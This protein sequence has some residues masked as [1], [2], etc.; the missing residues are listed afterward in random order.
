MIAQAKI[1]LIQEMVGDL[2]KE[3]IIWLSGYLSGLAG[4][5]TKLIPGETSLSNGSSAP[6][7]QKITIAYGTET[8]NA[9]KLASNLAAKAKKKG[10]QP[11]LVS[12]EQYK[13]TDLPKEEWFFTIISTQGE[14]E[15]P[16]GAKK[17]Y[18]FVHQ[19][20]VTLSKLNFGVLA[21]GDTSYPLFCKAGEDVDN[22]LQKLGGKRIV[23]LQKLD[24]DYEEEAEQWINN[25]LN[26][27]TA[28]ASAPASVT[29]AP[30]KKAGKKTYTGTIQTKINLNGR[31]SQKETYH[32]EIA[33]EDIVF[34]PGDAIGIVPKNKPELVQKI[35]AL[36]GLPEDALVPYRSETA[37]LG[38]LIAQKLSL[39]NLSEN[40]V[41]KYAEIVK[42][43]IPA[44]RMDFSDLLRI[45]PFSN[46]E[47]FLAA[48]Q[49][50]DPISPRLYSIASSPEAHAGEVHLTLG[51]HRFCVNEL[52]RDGLCSYYLSQ[53]KEGEEIDFYIHKNHL[54]KLPAEDKD[55]IMVGP[56]TGIAPFRSFVAHRDATGASGRNWLFFGDQHFTTDFLYQT[57]WQSWMETGVLTKM[58]VAFSRDQDEKLYVQH[59]L[60]QHRQELVQ[61]LD[62]GAYFYI[63]G[64]KE[65]MSVDVE[66]ILVKI[67]T[68]QKGT[69]EEAAAE[70]IDALKEEGRYLKDVY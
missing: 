45:Y 51:M 49:V 61:W 42:Q 13:L 52:M 43:E 1:K 8:G 48:L 46:S 69:S 34:E 11:K 62:N 10:I 4:A 56:G 14:G 40:V 19:D 37:P 57:E 29:V 12:L 64:A 21:L 35:I 59:K 36:S 41:K 50:L 24:T 3:E 70:Y 60:W 38:K 18:D 27:L 17:F 63:C 65:P 44:T 28:P 67:I 30:A 26:S 23:P 39:V 22:Q 7:V 6:S 53:M 31:G 47:Q 66:A 58:N 32:I 16:A 55:V 54:F 68:E 33:A 9:K 15:P 25:L 2:T 5:E 20:N